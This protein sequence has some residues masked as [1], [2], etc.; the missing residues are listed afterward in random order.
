MHN[1]KASDWLCARP[2]ST[3]QEGIATREI[4][5]KCDATFVQDFGQPSPRAAIFWIE[6]LPS[7]KFNTW[8]WLDWCWWHQWR[9]ATPTLTPTIAS[10]Y[11]DKITNFNGI[12]KG[13]GAS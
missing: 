2:V 12:N 5:A 11:I 10:K 1:E 6:L 4:E 8:V 9:S 3:V 7:Q 13:A